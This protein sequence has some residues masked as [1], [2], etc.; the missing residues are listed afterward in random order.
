MSPIE[1]AAN[2]AAALVAVDGRTYPLESARIDAFAEGGLA[3]STLTQT[4]AN[5]H[6]EPLEVTYTLP[7]PADGAVL[8]YRVRVGEKTITAEVQPRDRASEAYR[9]ALLTG[10]SAGLMEQLRDDTFQQTLGNVPPR[11]RVEIAIEVLHP[12]AFLTGTGGDGP[13]APHGAPEWE[14][15]FPTVAGVRYVGSPGRVP[16]ARDLSPDR[17]DDGN[18]PARV[19]L[20]LTIARV[21]AVVARSSSHAITQCTTD[22][23]VAVGF[24][25]G[26]RLDRDVVVCWDAAGPE[27]GVSLVEGG[28]LAGDDGRYALVTVVPSATPAVTFT[29]DLTVLIDASG[30]M[31]GAPLALAK[32]VVS[33]LCRSLAEG[34]RFELLAFASDV[35]RL[36]H[37][38]VPCDAETLAAAQSALDALAAGGATEMAHAMEQ[39]LAP[40]RDGAQRQVVLVTDGFIGF[41]NEIVRKIAV[42]PGTRVHAVGIGSAPNRALTRAVATASHGLELLVGDAAGAQR[43]VTRLIAG[44]ARPL[45]TNLSARGRALCDETSVVAGDVFAGRPLVFTIELR[46]EGGEL[47]LSADLAGTDER[48]VWRVHVPASGGM[49]RTILPIGTLYGRQRVADLELQFA[50]SNRSGGFD[51]EIERVAMRH[52]IASRCTSLVAIAEE[53]SVDPRAPRRRERLTVE[54]PV[55]V[56]AAGTGLQTFRRARL[57]MSAESVFCSP[58]HLYHHDLDVSLSAA[59]HECMYE[60]LEERFR[61]DDETQPLVIVS[62]QRVGQDVIIVEIETGARELPLPSNVA[63]VTVEGPGIFQELEAQVVESRTSRTSPPRTIA[64]LALRIPELTQWP[65]A[66]RLTVAWQAPRVAPGRAVDRFRSESFEVPPWKGEE[67]TGEL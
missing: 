16:D 56:S 23:G 59:S 50:G 9:E 1:Q 34:D 2:P 14:Y 66:I 61:E 53:P 12:L 30:S 5:P 47:D 67:R 54:M 26:E 58:I 38:M 65:S 60:M 63:E 3:F 7:L 62:V 31:D 32:Q 24:K 20:A 41:E 28:G 33:G 55:G 35:G 18:I 44:T 15:R 27:V 19:E 43:A 21:D 29:R 22:G 4:Y 37:G 48:W 42:C 13:R 8:G 36:T 52:R 40:M 11:T 45:L 17:A 51:Q 57:A 6:D 46:P 49:K 64:R 25:T 10:R 39:A